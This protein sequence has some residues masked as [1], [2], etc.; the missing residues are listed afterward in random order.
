MFGQ[1]DLSLKG[2]LKIAPCFDR[3]SRKFKFRFPWI[4][5]FV[6][7]GFP[8][9]V[10]VAFE[11]VYPAHPPRRNPLKLRPRTLIRFHAAAFV[12]TLASASQKLRYIFFV[13]E[14]AQRL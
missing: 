9:K 7:V 13:Y 11:V 12:L 6:H 5:V 10:L 8:V 1:K 14:F 4:V 2:L 3:T